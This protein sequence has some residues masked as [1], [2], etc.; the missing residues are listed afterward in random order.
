M[1]Y[2]VFGILYCLSLLPFSALYLLSSFFSFI[3]YYLIGYRKEVV[4]KNLSIAF[5]E[6][7]HAERKIIAKQFYR[8]FWD[9]WIE[10]LKL[11][12]ISEKQLRKHVTANTTILENIYKSGRSCHVLLGHQ[13]NWEWGNAF[14]TLQSPYTL[15]GA[16][17]PLTNKI[18]DRLMLYVRRRFGSILLPY[19]DM[20]RAM[21]PYRNRQYLLALMADQSPYNLRKSY[22]INFFDTATAFLQG[23]ERG[24]RLG[25]MPVVFVA[26]SKPGRGHYHIEASLLTDNAANMAEGELT[27]KYALLLETNIRRNPSVYLWSHK[28]WKHVW[29]DEYKKLGVDTREKL[30]SNTN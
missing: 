11:L 17:S 9:N 28:R 14:V 5:P 13:F 20:R 6:K 22:W 26:L 21:L 29:K 16:Y 8:H 27:K 19:N 4:F 25:N 7:T 24:A 15:L 30:M 1:Y 10:T 23:P 12:S 2:L 3:T 18:L